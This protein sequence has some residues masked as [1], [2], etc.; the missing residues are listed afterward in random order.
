MPDIRPGDDLAALIASHGPAIGD[1]IVVA[2]K[3]VSK[4]EGRIVDLAA[5]TPSAEAIAWA[6]KTDKD[7]RVVELVLNESARVLRA[8][9][10]LMIVEHRLGF[11][12]ANA[13]IDASNTGG[14]E[15]VI[16]LPENPDASACRLADGIKEACGAQVGVIVSDSWGRPW[17]LGT[18]GFAIGAAGLPALV[19]RR[20][21]PDRDGRELQ[22]TAIGLAD[23]LAAAA[24][25]LMGQAAEGRPIVVIR[26][27]AEDAPLGRAA[28]LIRPAADDLF[29]QEDA[30]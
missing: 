10:G 11:V 19:D 27:L 9:P 24:S 8:R 28:D 16:L 15:R 4:A 1:V 17:R 12:M 26:G 21:V 14:G 13:G 6:E 30:R 22:A 18:V 5:V 2:Q 25:L 7:P 29:R 20:G 23:E 3:I